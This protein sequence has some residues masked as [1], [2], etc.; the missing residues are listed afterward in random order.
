MQ[1][2]SCYHTR[3]YRTVAYKIWS[4]NTKNNNI[5]RQK[6]DL[7]LNNYYMVMK[8][9][10]KNKTYDTD[11]TIPKSNINIAEGGQIETIITEIHDRSLS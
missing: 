10:T 3:K 1:D 7:V 2:K 9:K 5:N 4:P 6:S 11:G 8:R